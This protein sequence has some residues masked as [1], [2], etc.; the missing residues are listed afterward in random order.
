M[1]KQSGLLKR[2][3]VSK[4]PILK[5]DGHSGNY[6]MKPKGVAGHGCESRYIK[7]KGDCSRFSCETR[8]HDSFGD[9]AK[10]STQDRLKDIPNFLGD[11]RTQHPV[12]QDPL[13]HKS[14]FSPKPPCCFCQNLKS[15]QI[16][17]ANIP[18]ISYQNFRSTHFIDSEMMPC[19]CHEQPMLWSSRHYRYRNSNTLTEDWFDNHSIP[20]YTQK[21]SNLLSD[22]KYVSQPSENTRRVLNAACSCLYCNEN[23]E[24]GL[25]TQMSNDDYK[26]KKKRCLRCGV[27]LKSD[28]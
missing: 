4:E 2:T 19:N 14:N 11:Q 22:K 15:L 13:F 25:S 28:S 10:R 6:L 20:Q 23:C 16:K 8:S 18:L 26:S 21:A 9:H 17:T 7:S 5:N 27:C 24:K 12:A 1:K 3:I